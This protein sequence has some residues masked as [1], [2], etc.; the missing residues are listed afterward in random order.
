MFGLGAGEIF[1]VAIIALVVFGPEKIPEIA[2][3]IGKSSADLK[4][5]SPKISDRE[6]R[7]ARDSSDQQSS[8]TPS[9]K[10]STN[11]STELKNHSEDI[12]VQRTESDNK[13]ENL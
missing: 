11:E 10:A 12:E 4:P 1:F 5:S 8:N 3:W 6:L 2:R 7:I 13:L 9:I